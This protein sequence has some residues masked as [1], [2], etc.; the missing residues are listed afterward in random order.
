MRG[1]PPRSCFL[2][3]LIALEVKSRRKTHVGSSWTYS[4]KNSLSIQYSSMKVLLCWDFYSCSCFFFFLFLDFFVFWGGC[5]LDCYCF[6][7][8]VK[9]DMA[10]LQFPG[11]CANLFI[12][13]MDFL[14]I[15]ICHISGGMLFGAGSSGEEDPGEV[16]FV[17]FL[18]NGLST[19]VFT[20]LVCSA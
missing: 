19:F 17:S 8:S 5:W 7:E 1:V 13:F 20:T 3:S 12:S 2:S 10:F 15:Y 14:E 4:S 6:Y 18:Q 16:G 9:G 11:I